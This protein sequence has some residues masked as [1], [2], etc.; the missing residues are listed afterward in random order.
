M[1][2]LHAA[3]ERVGAKFDPSDDGLDDLVRRR[4]RTL[5]RR[6]LTAGGLAIAVASGGLVVAVRALPSRSHGRPATFKVLA[7]L[8]PTAAATPT[9]A[10]SPG[11]TCP[12][13]SGNSPPPLVLAATSG[14]AGSSVDVSGR[15]WN[16][17]L[18]MQLW[19]N[20]G[21]IGDHIDPPPWPPTGPDLPFAPAGPGPVVRLAAVAGPATTGDCTFQATFTVPNVEPGTYQLQWVFGKSAEVRPPDGDAFFLMSSELSFEVTG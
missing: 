11:S 16:D 10:P 13:P 7:T 12:T 5:T 1:N 14:Q 18:W 9:A 20:A 21:E 2:D 8:T 6:R 19:W 15:F 4:R 17:E 3:I